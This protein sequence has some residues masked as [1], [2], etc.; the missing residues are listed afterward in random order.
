MQTPTEV[1]KSCITW[2]ILAEY[3]ASEK[4]SQAAAGCYCKFHALQKVLQLPWSKQCKGLTVEGLEDYCKEVAK[5]SLVGNKEI[6]EV[7][8]NLDL[9]QFYIKY[10]INHCN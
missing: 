5:E 10:E 2:G 4:G 6:S 1:I 3:T 9:A 8:Q 7:L